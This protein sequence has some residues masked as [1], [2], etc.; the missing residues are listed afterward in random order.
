MRIR[1]ATPGQVLRIVSILA[2]LVAQCCSLALPG[3]APIVVHAN[4]LTIAWD[5]PRF[6]LPGVLAIRS[7][8]LFYRIHGTLSWTEVAE[9]PASDSPKYTLS[10][11]QLGDGSFDVAVKAVNELGQ[12]SSI[13]SSTDGNTFPAGG[14]YVIWVGGT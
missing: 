10:H 3:A 8:Q 5:P 1:G 14:W 12:T 7:Y 9:V 2:L 4:E 13:H 6:V 11:A